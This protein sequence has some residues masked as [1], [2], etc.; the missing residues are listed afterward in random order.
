MSVV[1]I[2]RELHSHPELAYHE[3][4]TTQLIVDQLAAYGLA[5]E[6]LAGR[7]GRHSATSAAD[8]AR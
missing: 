2:R 1:A 6:V 8:R 7:D 4:K 5:P 3:K